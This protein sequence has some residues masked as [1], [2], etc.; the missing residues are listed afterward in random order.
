MLWCGPWNAPPIRRTRYW[1]FIAICCDDCGIH[2]SRF[3]AE[4]KRET[5]TSCGSDVGTKF[6]DEQTSGSESALEVQLRDCKKVVQQIEMEQQVRVQARN[7]QWKL[8]QW[9][10]ETAN[11]R[12]L[13]HRRHVLSSNISGDA[14]SGEDRLAALRVPLSSGAEVVSM[15]NYEKT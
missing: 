4:G 11:H 5:E 12:C 1:E 8:K 2:T 7:I 15:P 13:K 3:F 9:F 6:L 14:P 10:A